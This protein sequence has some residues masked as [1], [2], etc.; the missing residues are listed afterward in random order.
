MTR[1]RAWA[2]ALVT[3]TLAVFLGAL[4]LSAQ[5]TAKKRTPP[6]PS[7]GTAQK[8]RPPAPPGQAVPR[9]TPPKPR[10]PRSPDRPRPPLPPP[11]G[12]YIYPFAPFVGFDFVYRFPF[13]A[14][15]Y[16]RYGYPESPYR[17]IFPPPGCVAI[18]LEAHGGVRIDVPQREATVHVDGFYVGVVDDFNGTLEHLNLTPGPHHIELHAPGFETT[19]FEVNIE[20]GHVIVYRTPM[21]AG[22]STPPGGTQP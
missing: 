21:R 19:V 16:S 17:F 10:E 9:Q 15:P 4:P 11:H 6:A 18:E 14:Y 20:A 22:G 12:T 5:S 1:T 3:A 2:R 7:S 8:R 13:G